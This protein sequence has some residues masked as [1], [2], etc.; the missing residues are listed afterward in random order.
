MRRVVGV[1]GSVI[2]ATLL[3]ATLLVAAAARAEPSKIKGVLYDVKILGW[4]YREDLESGVFTLNLTV[5]FKMANCSDSA[6]V[7]PLGLS[8]VSANLTKASVVL[9]GEELAGKA[10]LVT[11]P[12][13]RV[14][15]ALKKPVSGPK[16]A[17]VTVSIVCQ[18]KSGAKIQSGYAKDYTPVSDK[19][20]NIPVT[21]YFTSVSWEK[22]GDLPGVRIRVC[23]PSGWNAVYA[24]SSITSKVATL[25]IRRVDSCFEFWNLDEKTVTP[26]SL[27]PGSSFSA[28]VAVLPAPSPS[29]PHVALVAL[30]LVAAAC[31]FAWY[32]RDVYRYVELKVGG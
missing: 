29:Q 26:K 25:D 21:N 15:I 6:L 8:F 12:L 27:S 28:E 18:V 3:V 4:E 31:F 17:T 2:L 1:K 20:L 13:S 14:E 10:K 23:P 16:W 30:A 9:D 11:K 24:V 22:D 7:V 19:V 32:Y 5:S